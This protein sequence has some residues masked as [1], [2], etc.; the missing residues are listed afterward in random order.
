MKVGILKRNW[1]KSFEVYQSNVCK[2]L[3]KYEVSFEFF[4]I[5]NKNIVDC[6]LIWTQGAPIIDSFRLLLNVRIPVV[7]TIHGVDQFIIP[8]KEHT[9]SLKS[10]LRWK[11][12]KPIQSIFWR[13]AKGHIS[14]FVTVSQ[15]CKK[16][17]QKVYH[18]E[19]DRLHVVYHG[20]DDSVFNEKIKSYKNNN[21]YFLHISN[22]KPKKNVGR[23]IN[24]FESLLMNYPD[25]E[26]L[27]VAPLYREPIPNDPRIKFIDRHNYVP[28]ETLAKLY[29][30]ALGF[31]FP[32]IDETFGLPILEAMACGCPVVTSNISACPEI[33]G[34][35]AL[36]VNPYNVNEIYEAMRKI[37]SEPEKR[38]LLIE[39]SRRQREKFSWDKSAEQHYKV[40]SKVLEKNCYGASKGYK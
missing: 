5:K 7:T 6:D 18:I 4:D 1:G 16:C 20:Y 30:G 28:Q 12:K 11:V 8:S 36:L 21:Q 34:D 23:I 39:K 2:K 33:A 37:V 19:S 31:V 14:N 15:Y 40:F 27:I 3:Q 38:N 24:A 35:A 9:Y 32:S 22:G 17:L 26:L 29:K 13:V 10:R 25:I